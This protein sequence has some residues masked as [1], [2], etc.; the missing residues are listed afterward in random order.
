MSDRAHRTVKRSE[1]DIVKHWPLYYMLDTFQKD[2]A[3]KELPMPGNV[4]VS[5]PHFANLKRL[6]EAPDAVRVS[7]DFSKCPLCVYPGDGVSVRSC[8]II[9][10]DHRCTVLYVD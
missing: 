6:L 9:D 2:R 1:I 7:I 5:T 10:W 8:V 4:H 3:S